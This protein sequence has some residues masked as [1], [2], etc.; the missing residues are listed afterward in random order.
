[1]WARRMRMDPVRYMDPARSH[2]FGMILWIRRIIRRSAGMECRQ[3]KMKLRP[4][5]A[6]CPPVSF[7]E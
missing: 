2:E 3:K 6:E 5:V 1:M 7:A 4:A